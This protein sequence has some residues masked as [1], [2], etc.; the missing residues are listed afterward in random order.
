[1]VFD[2]AWS[3]DGSRLAYSTGCFGN[4]GPPSRNWGLWLFDANTGTGRLLVPGS[5][6]DGDDIVA[7]DW[8]P[9]DTRIAFAR[10][11]GGVFQVDVGTASVEPMTPEYRADSLS[12]SPDGLRIAISTRG[13][14]MFVLRLS[15][16][17]ATFLGNG[18]QPAWSP[19]GTR[20]AYRRPCELWITTEDG[21]DHSLLTSFPKDTWGH[22]SK[23]SCEPHLRAIRAL[24]PVWS[25]D[26]KKLAAVFANRLNVVDVD[27][28]DI[29]ILQ[30]PIER[31]LGGIG[32]GIAWR[33]VPS[34]GQNRLG[35]G[36]G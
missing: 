23:R 14:E 18:S 34:D 3:A 2:A 26:G 11:L 31:S 8:S 22:V 19:D 32:M 16:T 36:D 29:E 27:D 20:L 1:M 9:D 30:D 5:Q 6:D 28:G 17:E 13:S 21:I 15:G 25:P 33:P 35:E 12:W 10:D 4:C 24:G 7:L